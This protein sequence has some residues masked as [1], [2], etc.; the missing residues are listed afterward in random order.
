MT[1]NRSRVLRWTTPLLGGAIALTMAGC[2]S[3]PSPSHIA[4]FWTQWDE[5]VVVQ[6]HG[7]KPTIEIAN[8]GPGSIGRVDIMNGDETTSLSGI[9]PHGVSMF[10]L[11]EGSRV[12]IADSSGAQAA[13]RIWSAD[14]Y[15]L[16]AE[17]RSES[18]SKK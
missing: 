11:R 3:Q 16:V 2:A 7:Q 13:L 4:A 14:T 12:R 8:Q 15:D 10:T 6:L 18:A 9:P 5:D 1:Q 17:D